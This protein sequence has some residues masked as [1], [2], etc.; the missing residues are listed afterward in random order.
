MGLSRHLSRTATHRKALLRNLVTALLEY[1][2]ITT[3][4]AKAKETQATAEWLITL[5]KNKS[6]NVQEAKIRAQDL[7][8][9]PKTTIPKLFDDIAERYK[10][11]TGGYTRV[12]KLEPR[13]GDNAP[14]SILE[15]I[16]GKRDMRMA[17]TARIVA[18]LEQQGQAVDDITKLNVTKIVNGDPGM[19]KRFRKEVEFMKERFYANPKTVEHVRPIIAPKQRAVVRILENPLAKKG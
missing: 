9:K 15:L 4:H 13:L 8:F 3:T 5:A 17:I 12:L 1:E 7:I 10:D 2:S 6:P 19:E 11:R 18:R 16:G 14:Q